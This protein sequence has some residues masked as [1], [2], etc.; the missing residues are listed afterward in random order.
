[1][2]P[3]ILQVGAINTQYLKNTY[4]HKIIW[5]AVMI[6]DISRNWNN[7]K[8]LTCYY[9]LKSGSSSA[10]QRNSDLYPDFSKTFHYEVEVGEIKKVA[11]P[12]RRF[13]FPITI[14]IN[15]LGTILLTAREHHSFAIKGKD[16]LGKRPRVFDGLR[17]TSKWLPKT[18]WRIM[19][20][21]KFNL[22]EN[23]TWCNKENT[24]LMRWR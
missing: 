2:T 5:L 12:Y 8:L 10:A 14:M 16:C 11:I 24:V 7:E 6:R 3:S 9:S 20:N 17:N 23:W 4:C 19:K 1:L 22:E 13:N 21:K 18:N 15:W